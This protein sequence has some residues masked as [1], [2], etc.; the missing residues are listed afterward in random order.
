M[1]PDVRRSA[2]VFAALAL[3]FGV[4]VALL[5]GEAGG[6]RIILGNLSAPW[7]LLP[8]FAGRARRTPVSGAVSGGAV[9]VLSLVGFYACA[10]AAY[11]MVNSH[12]VTTDAVYFVGA[13]ISGPLFGA[14]G[15]WSRRSLAAGAVVGLTL[16]A[17]PVAQSRGWRLHGTQWAGMSLLQRH[18]A[19]AAAE[20]LLGIAVGAWLLHHR[21]TRAGQ[22]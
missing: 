2:A 6:T 21:A 12:T 19:I 10:G 13:A 7:L 1:I 11:G 17:E 14:L 5:K 9:A 16:V 20:M 18:P 15:Y 3:G 22:G 8:F 4:A